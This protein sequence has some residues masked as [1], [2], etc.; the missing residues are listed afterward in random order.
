MYAPMNTIDEV[1]TVLADVGSV[2]EAIYEVT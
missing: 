1:F 2:V